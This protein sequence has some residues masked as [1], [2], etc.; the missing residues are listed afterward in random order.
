MLPMGGAGAQE[1]GDAAQSAAT[2]AVASGI[3]WAPFPVE[4]WVNPFD[5]DGP[6]EPL[7][8]TPLATA[9]KAWRLCVTI[10]HVKDSYWLAVNYGLAKES[11]RLDVHLTLKEAGGYAHLDRHRAQ[12]RACIEGDY[13]ALIVG[14]ISY[15]EQNDL[16]AEARAAGKPVIDLVNGMSSPA[17]TAKSLVS[18]REMAYQAGRFLRRSAAS[19]ARIG[20]FPGPKGAGWVADGD[21]GL[22]AALAESDVE[23]LETMHG[24]TTPEA[25]RQLVRD[26]L[27]RHPDVDVIVGTAVTVSQAA[28]ELAARDRAG[29]IA[30]VSYYLTQPVYRGLQKGTIQAAPTDSPVV[31]ARIAVDQAVRVL[32]GKPYRKHVGPRVYVIERFNVDLFEY[33]TALAPNVF[34]P[35]MSVN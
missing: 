18:F 19:D 7:D 35:V 5:M 27:D 25:Q 2:Q 12:I 34:T 1:I 6:R 30:L 22:R 11:R 3:P 14:A 15:T 23:I 32:E 13:D 24:D 9:E 28:A 16:V 4:V 33:R 17:L 21:E 26:F 10:P 8:Y 31:Q 20:W 29:E